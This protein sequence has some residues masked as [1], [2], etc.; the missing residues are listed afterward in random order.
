MANDPSNP[1]INPRVYDFCVRAFRSTRKLLKLNIKLHQENPGENSLV[2]QGD[3]FL[4]NHFSRFETFIPQYLIREETGAY[5]RS[6]AAAEFFDGDER[7]SQ[8]LYDIGVVPNDLPHL[9]PFLVR[10]IL[11]D[12]KLIVFPANRKIGF[13]PVDPFVL[14]M[15]LI[16][17]KFVLYIQQYEDGCSKTDR[18]S[19][20]VQYGVELVS[21]DV[22][23][24]TYQIV[25]YHGL[26][27][28]VSGSKY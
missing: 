10:E 22:T 8:F 4:F 12:R 20:N 21:C 9:F 5:C 24:K 19:Y 28:L 11:H 27:I 7:F 2:R 6:V 13:Y 23:I 14:F 3:I 26:Q 15:V 1:E 17:R 25:F 18:E 16:I